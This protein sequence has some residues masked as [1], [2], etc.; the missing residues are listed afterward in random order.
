MEIP[1]VNNGIGGW[2]LSRHSFG[3]GRRTFLFGQSPLLFYSI[4]RKESPNQEMEAPQRRQTTCAAP[5]LSERIFKN[6]STPVPWQNL[7]PIPLRNG[8]RPQKSASPDRRPLQRASARHV[9]GA[10]G[11]GGRIHPGDRRG[12]ARGRSRQVGA[13]YGSLPQHKR[14][15][16]EIGLPFQSVVEWGCLIPSSW[17]KQQ[18]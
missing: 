11:A 1:A 10:I 8:P 13:I 15:I 2:G 12:G 5:A 3:E 18:S 7:P 6:C 16:E 4:S 9:S 17:E 14:A